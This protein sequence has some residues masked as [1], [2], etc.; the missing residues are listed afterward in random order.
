MAFGDDAA[1]HSG[2]VVCLEVHVVDL[3]FKLHREGA[4]RSSVDEPGPE[5]YS[6]A[7]KS[8]HVRSPLQFVLAPLEGVTVQITHGMI[9]VSRTEKVNS[10][11]DISDTVE[12]IFI[13]FKEM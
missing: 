9:S 2:L 4:G 3:T 6:S 13:Y 12:L 7:E 8:V 10:I 5:T 11:T 1:A